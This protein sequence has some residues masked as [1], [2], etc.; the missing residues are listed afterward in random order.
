MKKLVVLSGAGVSAE[1]GIS[2]FRDSGGLWEGYDILEVAS[3]EG[4]QKDKELV[5]NFYNMRRKNMINSIPNDAHLAIAQL[6]NNYNTVVITQNVDD[7]HER[8]GSKNVIHLHGELRKSR[9]TANSE[10]IYNIIGE[11]LNIGDL[12]ELGSQLRPHIV[13]FGEEVPLMYN[14]IN[15]VSKADIILIIGTSMVVYPAASLIHYA[16]PEI[17]VY[18]IDPK[19]PD[20]KFNK[21]VVHIAE[22]ATVGIKILTTKYLKV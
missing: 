1:S 7:L 8:A 15:E 21:N 16:N 17:P 12:C 4:W 10:L 11:E 18:Y 14:A 19:I 22:K 9:S 2:T 6:Q 13:W 20:F 5:L 3:I